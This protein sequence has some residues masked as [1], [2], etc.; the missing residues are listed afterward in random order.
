MNLIESYV[1]EVGQNLPKKVRADIESEIRSLIQDTL[2]D[3]SQAAGQAVDEEM[4]VAVL[5]EFGP[6]AKMA[7]SYLPPRYLI[8]PRLFPTF[9]LVIRIVLALVAIVSLVRLGVGFG[10]SGGTPEAMGRVFSEILTGFITS[11]LSVLGNV[12]FIF[13]ILEW[14]LP[15][16]A[17][18]SKEWDPR[19]L[20]E[21]DES[22]DARP[23]SLIW[24]IAW[25]VVAL[26]IFNFYP[27]W[28]GIGSLSNGTWTFAPILSAEF[29]RYLPWL[30]GIWV[31]YIA[32]DVIL[33]R[34]GRW[35]AGT[36]WFKAALSL[37]NLIILI[38]MALGA[39]IVNLPQLALQGLEPL[40][41]FANYGV[42]ALLVFIA[43]MEG[44]ELVKLLY[45]LV[46][47]RT[48]PVLA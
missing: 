40:V 11:A 31:L 26:L 38:L 44:L 19:S 28:V 15:K 48:T 27:Q 17:G 25:I 5:K 43:T 36:R 21:R 47:K 4:V 41:P 46:V 12:V 16:V 9:I 32:L 3:R 34:S 30:S 13:A 18:K 42:R 23:L 39:P 1:S 37:V 14:A 7:A 6:P 10:Q 22:E 20:K 45:R 35:Q 29:F 24:E 8:G 33:L 2:E